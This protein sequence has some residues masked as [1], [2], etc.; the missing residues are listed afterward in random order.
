MRTMFNIGRS[1]LLS[2]HEHVACEGL[3]PHTLDEQV[4]EFGIHLRPIYWR[5]GFAEEAGHEIITL[6]FHTL[7]AMCLFA[8]HHPANA[9]SR[10]LLHKLGFRFTHEE[11]YPPTGM[12]HRERLVSCLS[13][14]VLL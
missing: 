8:G 6:A 4:Y 12:K 11:F 7:G 10:R 13:S 9:T 1:S 5:Q 3:R 2:S 14:S